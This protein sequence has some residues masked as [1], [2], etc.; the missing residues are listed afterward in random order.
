M[1]S[2]LF[3][4]KNRPAAPAQMGSNDI[5]RLGAVL[6]DGP[7]VVS[8]ETAPGV[9]LYA[10]E[11]VSKGEACRL[12]R[13]PDSWKKERP[14]VYVVQLTRAAEV[15]NGNKKATIEKPKETTLAVMDAF[16]FLG[17]EVFEGV[18]SRFDRRDVI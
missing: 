3:D 4:P 5:G 1:A 7:L 6:K 15:K 10:S 11:C 18:P 13:V 16:K 17:C 12:P 8:I 2:P 14:R 9:F